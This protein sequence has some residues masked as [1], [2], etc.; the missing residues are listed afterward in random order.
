MPAAESEIDAP[1]TNRL[2]IRVKLISQEPPPPPPRWRLSK[3]ALLL[4]LGVVA[5]LLGWLAISMFR[6]DPTVPPAATEVAP[7]V[8]PTPKPAE[9]QVKSVAP[10]VRQLP[11]APPS[12]I[13]EA[14]PAVPQS[15]LAT[16]TGTIKISVRVTIDKQGTVV[17]A[18]AVERGPS[19]YFERLAK[20]ASKKWTFTPA[21]SD[22]RRTM[23]VRFNFTRGRVTA[24]AGPPQ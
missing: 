2:V 5:V 4:I 7:V 10:A 21:T 6:S 23:L 1:P 16:I 8:E 22:E 3:S 11:D 9:P 18:A 12:P 17:D 20:E 19:R 15:A 14:I 24:Q 13:D